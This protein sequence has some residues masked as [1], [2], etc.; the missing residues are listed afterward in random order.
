LSLSPSHRARSGR[1]AI[2]LLSLLVL[3]VSSEAARRRARE[4][5]VPTFTMQLAPKSLTRSE[6]PVIVRGA[7]LPGMLGRRMEGLR[8][9]ALRGSTLRPIPFQADEFDKKGVIVSPEGK[10][11]NKDEDEGL[12]DANDEVVMM[13]MDLGGRAPRALQPRGA[14]AAVEIEVADP[15][16]GGR[17]W[18]YLLDFDT[19]PAR[20]PV[21]YVRYDPQK[22][23]AET[24]LYV[25]DFNE[26]RAVLLDDMRIKNSGGDWGPNLIDR[27][28][29]RLTFKT[30]T[31]LTF[32][33][34]EEDI[35]SR[36]SA[37]K[38][39]PIRAVRATEY[40]IRLFFIKVTPTAHVDYLFY[41]NAVVGPSEV[42][43]PFSPKL[44]LRGGSHAVSGLDFDAN[45]YGWRFYSEANPK[46]VVV[47]GETKEGD[48]LRK[49]GVKWFVLYGR[50]GG[51]LTRVVYG[52]SLLKAKLGYVLYYLDDKQKDGKPERELG[53]TLLGF[54][55]DLRRIPRGKHQLWFYQ[56]FGVPFRLGDEKRFN[57]IL[58]NPLRVKALAVAPAAAPSRAGA[59]G[60]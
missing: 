28:K 19:P 21:S 35:H 7:D 42:K 55:V 6:D 32:H 47:N 48:G 2:L 3:P 56:Y 29:V 52:E 53:Q 50:N 45:V 43:I 12:L 8:A 30:R 59:A 23:L 25:V 16:T 39:G 33:F 36:V 22:D 46:P 27:I 41:R 13:A 38:N 20:S 54:L 4:A 24:P 37:Y 9:Y 11:P 34:D 18:F 58:D 44:V 26:E 14:R 40:D 60:R 31:F 15:A 1:I 51:T 5:P 17:G 57:D 10:D 49:D